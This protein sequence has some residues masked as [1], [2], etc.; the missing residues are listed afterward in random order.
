[1]ST[2]DLDRFI[3]PQDAVW[4]DVTQELKAGRKRTH[5]MWFIFPQLRGLGRSDRAIFWG[6]AHLT[7]AKGFVAHP[8]LG[9]RLQAVNGLMLGHRGTDPV[10]ILGPVDAAKLQSSATLFEAA[11]EP[12]GA[13]VLDAFYGG[14]R[15]GR[16]LDLLGA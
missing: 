14:A 10:T 4:A 9:P 5:W 12:S 7:E 2:D 6:I 11:A 15:C 13:A 1:M 16:T 3:A 8:V